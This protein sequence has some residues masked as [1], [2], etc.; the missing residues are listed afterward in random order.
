M[1][2]F[3]GCRNATVRGAIKCVEVVDDSCAVASALVLN[4]N[5]RIARRAFSLRRYEGE[6]YPAIGVE[7]TESQL[8]QSRKSRLQWR[9]MCL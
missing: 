1:S 9:I 8:L 2:G 3:D 5:V 6:V 7:N 4:D